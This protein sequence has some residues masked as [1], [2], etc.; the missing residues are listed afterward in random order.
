MI[1]IDRIIF[2][3]N[4]AGASNHACI[5]INASILTLNPV[6]LPYHVITYTEYRRITLITEITF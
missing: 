5:L 2:K 3:P 4:K 6:A 1:Y